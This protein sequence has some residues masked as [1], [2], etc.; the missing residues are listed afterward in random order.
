MNR[1]DFEMVQKHNRFIEENS[2]KHPTI[3]DYLIDYNEDKKVFEQLDSN[4]QNHQFKSYFEAVMTIEDL[5][6]LFCID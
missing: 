5:K 2:S 6:E 4:W 1:N 3:Y